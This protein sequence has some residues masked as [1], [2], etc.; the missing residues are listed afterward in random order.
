MRLTITSVS[1][2][3]NV[4]NFSKKAYDVFS[5]VSSSRLGQKDRRERI[6]A[7]VFAL[8]DD[9]NMAAGNLQVQNQ[10]QEVRVHK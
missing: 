7:K 5:S 1:N 4:K 10:Q 3:Q 8:D 6:C 9:D 2:G